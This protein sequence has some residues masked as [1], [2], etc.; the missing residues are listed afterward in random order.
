MK[1]SVREESEIF[2]ELEELCKSDG[3]IHAIAYFCFRDNT[4]RYGDSVTSEDL[5][6]PVSPERL[7]RTE[8]STL[9]GLMHKSNINFKTPA[10]EVLQNYI[11]KT[12]SLLHEIHQSMMMPIFQGKSIEDFI[13]NNPFENGAVLRESIFYSGEAAYSFQYRDFSIEKYQKDNDW[14][15]KNK[16][17]TVRDVV[18]IISILSQYQSDK[19]TKTISKLVNIDPSEWTVLPAF[20][21]TADEISEEYGIDRDKISSILESFSIESENH[22]E[23]FQH[24]GD[25]NVVNAYP[26]IRKTDKEFILLQHYSLVEAFYETPFFWFNSD[27]SYKNTAMINRG[28]FTEKFS[29]ARL[30]KV[31]GENRVFTNI[32]LFDKN[33]GKAGEIDVLVVFANRAIIL[34]AKSKKLTIA[35]RKGNDNVL[36]DDFKKAVQDAYNQG[37]SCAE[38]IGDRNIV[39][40]DSDSNTININRD[41]KEKYIFCILSDHY[42]ALSFQSRQFLEY[43]E[44]EQIMAPFVMDVF[45]LDV[46]T[47]MLKSPLY[48][49]SYINRRALYYDRINSVQELTILSYHLK[50]NLWMQEESSFYH[51]SEDL[52]SDLDLAMVTRREGLPGVDTPEGILTMNNGTPVGELIKQIEFKEDPGSVDFGFL[53]LSLSGETVDQINL[54]ITSLTEKAIHDCKHHDLTI[55]IK[56]EKTGLTIHFNTKNH[57]H[58][59]A[60]LIEHCARR[61]Y[62]EK[63]DSWQGICLD[64]ND[65]HI[66]LGVSIEHQW[67]YSSEMD[68]IIKAL[69][70]PQTK[71]NPITIVK[72]RK[73]GRNE[74]CLCGSGKKF[75]RC[76]LN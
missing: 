8:I 17:F 32:D 35:A 56:G 63:A 68:S 38:L 71:T 64:P 28:E 66:K 48:F 39:L 5:M 31:F 16:G 36:K 3:Y 54:G 30:K 70:K 37:L 4:V 74:Q 26:I 53:L 2:S 1:L 33:G 20:T 14:F 18:E 46:M 11:E 75:K 67:E 49:L 51:L 40:K 52:S 15:E 61:K 10:P 13:E 12:Q 59:A 44:T 62:A 41:F 60:S 21:F 57:S 72:S 47:E 22:N 19:L 34:Q 76:C 9:I 69:P 73:I 43:K 27:K 29:E 42:P 6:E 55:G 50:Q 23:Q 45:L 7:I 24:I 25:F 65:R 58:A